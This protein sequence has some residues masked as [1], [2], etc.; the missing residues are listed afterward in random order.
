MDEPSGKSNVG[1]FPNGFT[2]G[3]MSPGAIGP[4]FTSSNN[5]SSI[6]FVSISATKAFRAKGEGRL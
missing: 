4:I 2:A 3:M 5:T 6:C 1:I